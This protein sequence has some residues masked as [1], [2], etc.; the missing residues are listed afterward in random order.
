MSE[1]QESDKQVEQA[2]QQAHDEIARLHEN[3][4]AALRQRDEAESQQEESAATS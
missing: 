4:T 2:A 3:A 1:Q